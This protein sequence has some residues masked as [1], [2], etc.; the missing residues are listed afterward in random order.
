MLT[1]LNNIQKTSRL[2][3]LPWR[4]TASFLTWSWRGSALVKF[5][6]SYLVQLTLWVLL[7]SSFVFVC[8]V[9]GFGFFVFL[10]FWQN[11]FSPEWSYSWCETLPGESWKSDGDFDD[12]LLLSLG[13][14]KTLLMSGHCKNKTL[15]SQ[16]FVVYKVIYICVCSDQSLIVFTYWQ[17][18]LL[19]LL[20]VNS[21]V[22]RQSYVPKPFNFVQCTC[23]DI[24]CIFLY[25][26]LCPKLG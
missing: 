1:K 24:F 21:C 26:A 23:L 15:P 17:L 16:M 12:F 7:L 9:W 11:I 22:V 25:G 19:K 5:D 18:Y 8:F 14:M 20:Y 2:V 6:P 10:F 3:C 4:L 13:L